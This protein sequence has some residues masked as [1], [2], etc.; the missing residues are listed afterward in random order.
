MEFT[1]A[2]LDIVAQEVTDLVR[3]EP[4]VDEVA[5]D[6]E[7]DLALDQAFANK[8][9]VSFGQAMISSNHS[10]RPCVTYCLIGA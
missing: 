4:P 3:R 1:S 9:V 5:P 8:L 6:A 10:I 2:A 7:G